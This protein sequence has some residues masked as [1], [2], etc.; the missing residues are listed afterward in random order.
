MVSATCRY[1]SACRPLL[2]SKCP[3]RRPPVRRSS[4]TTSSWVGTRCISVFTFYSCA[5]AFIRGQISSCLVSASAAQHLRNGAEDNL[6]I[7]RQR[8]TV[9][10]LHIQFHPRLKI[11]G[12]APAHGPQARQTR[13]HPQPP[14]L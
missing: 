3:S 1:S 11:H 4:A 14:A 6:P 10:V 12:I 8:P 9:D 2:Y 5:F 7:E 13:A